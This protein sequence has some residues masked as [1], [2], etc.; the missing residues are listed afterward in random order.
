MNGAVVILLILLM[1]LV[2]IFGPMVTI[3]A[4]NTLFGLSIPTTLSTWF[5]TLWI[6][7]IVSSA[8]ISTKKS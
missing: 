7:A 5:A 1:V 8:K 6:T 3:W 4:L 2:V